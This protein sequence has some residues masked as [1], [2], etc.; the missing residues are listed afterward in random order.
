MTKAFPNGNQR[1]RSWYNNN[2]KLSCIIRSSFAKRARWECCVLCYQMTKVNSHTHTHTMRTFMLSIREMKIRSIAH[3]QKPLVLFPWSIYIR[4]YGGRRDTVHLCRVE[5]FSRKKLRRVSDGIRRHTLP[6]SS[7]KL[8]TVTRAK[9][10]WPSER[11]ARIHFC[12]HMCVCVY[13]ARA[14]VCVFVCEQI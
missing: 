14:C 11:A 1:Q 6:A 2:W 7:P 12:T 13:R 9:S 4:T 8:K 5:G 3:N 10:L